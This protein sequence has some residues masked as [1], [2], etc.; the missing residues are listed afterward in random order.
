[1]PIRKSAFANEYERECFYKIS[2]AF[3]NEY[4]IY[5]N[6]PF[7]NILEP[8]ITE[9][10]ALALSNEEWD[11]LKKTSVDYVV[12]NEKDE[13]II[14]IEYD[15]L[16]QGYN[17]DG[18]YGA[19]SLDEDRQ[20]KMNLKIKIAEFFD[21]PFIIV[22]SDLFEDLSESLEMTIVDGLIAIVLSS[23]EFEKVLK[24]DNFKKAPLFDE[25]SGFDK[26]QKLEFELKRKL[27]PIYRRWAE[28]VDQYIA[29]HFNCSC[30]PLHYPN[31]SDFSCVK[32]V[33]VETF[34]RIPNLGEITCRV[35]MPRYSL[36]G[37]N[38]SFGYLD[39]PE[40]ISVVMAVEKLL[41]ER[42]STG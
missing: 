8:N 21:F 17:V 29:P 9:R 35:L 7:L 22:G 24:S 41:H 33:G 4:N 36:K 23:L 18:K 15:G 10:E 5:H 34:V 1:M 19:Q 42:K 30:I 14:I 20:K 40:K 13:P 16:R 32:L 3:G 27:N 39:L 11:Y 6:L 25:L 31:D 38:L 26:Y 2:R 28:V 37:D 12:C